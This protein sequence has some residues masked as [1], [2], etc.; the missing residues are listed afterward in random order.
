MQ[1]LHCASHKDDAGYSLKGRFFQIGCNG[2]HDSNEL[3][4]KQLEREKD[5][6]E[7]RLTEEQM[8]DIEKKFFEH[9]CFAIEDD[10]F[11]IDGH[12]SVQTILKAAEYIRTLINH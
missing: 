11:M 4:K 5:E 7:I 1:V 2:P 8:A 6:A 3:F 9:D 12:I 10:V